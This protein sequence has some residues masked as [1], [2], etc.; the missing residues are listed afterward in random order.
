[1][2]AMADVVDSTVSGGALTSTTGR[3]AERRDAFDGS[4]TQAATGS[5]T[6]WS[7]TDAR[8]TGAAWTVSVSATV[9]TSAAG[10]TELVARTLPVGN[11]TITPG[12]ITA[13][14]GSDAAAGI[15]APALTTSHALVAAEATHKGT[16]TLTSSFSLA[17][18]ANAFRSNYAVGSSG[19]LNP[20]TT[21]VT[22][23]IA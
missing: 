6:Q 20:Y 23:T 18:P 11:L 15:I 13:G 5:S 16:Y 8:G 21:T 9:P 4:N 17:I 10:T 3:H 19:A 2:P 22:Y 12:A 7:I 14:A 1:M